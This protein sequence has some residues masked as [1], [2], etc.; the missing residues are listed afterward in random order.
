M[1]YRCSRLVH[2]LC[3]TIE[4]SLCD[5]QILEALQIFRKTSLL[6]D[7]P[8]DSCIHC[9]KMEISEPH[10]LPTPRIFHKPLT[11][12][13]SIES[14]LPFDGRTILRQMPSVH[15]GDFRICKIVK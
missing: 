15:C 6:P 5:S 7:V 14:V 11:P 12:I 3:A 1:K 4:Y 9:R 2:N 13:D 10:I 8:A